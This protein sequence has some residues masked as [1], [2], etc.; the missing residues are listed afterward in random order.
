MESYRF[1]PPQLRST[2]MEY[3][4]LRPGAPGCHHD[5][6]E[7]GWQDRISVQDGIVIVTF[8]CARC[9]RQLAQPLDE[10]LAPASWKGG[11]SRRKAPQAVHPVLMPA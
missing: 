8:T 10:A 6:L 4:V 7:S 3:Q 11:P 5:L 2:R 9:G 1:Y